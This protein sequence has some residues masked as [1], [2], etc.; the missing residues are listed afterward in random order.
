MSEP[1]I[2]NYKCGLRTI[3]GPCC[4]L[5]LGHDGPHNDKAGQGAAEV[6]RL[7][8]LLQ[9]ARDHLDCAWCEDAC[10]DAHNALVAR[11]DAEMGEES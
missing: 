2:T 5:A 11:I 4:E 8:Q 7:R 9:E 3:P 6:E 1:K 10:V